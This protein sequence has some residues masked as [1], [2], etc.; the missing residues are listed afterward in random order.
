MEIKEAVMLAM[1]VGAHKIKLMGEKG[2]PANLLK[3]GLRRPTNPRWLNAD[4]NTKQKTSW[5]Q[6][7]RQQKRV[8]NRARG[9]EGFH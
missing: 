4:L 8:R 7:S 6:N 3:P 1:T 2:L 5:I 9:K